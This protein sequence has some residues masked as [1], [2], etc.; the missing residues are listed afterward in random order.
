MWSIPFFH[1]FLFSSSS[2]GNNQAEKTSQCI[3]QC[4]RLVDKIVL[5]QSFLQLA[6][7][8]SVTTSHATRIIYLFDPDPPRSD[9]RAASQADKVIC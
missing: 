3:N 6:A 1:F 2:C 9:R 7:L 4:S 8:A 5:S